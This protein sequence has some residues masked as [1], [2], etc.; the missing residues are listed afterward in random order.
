MNQQFFF[1]KNSKNKVKV[2]SAFLSVILDLS[3]SLVRSNSQF[4]EKNEVLLKKKAYIF[5]DYQ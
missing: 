1:A 5:A 3:F 4:H 2:L